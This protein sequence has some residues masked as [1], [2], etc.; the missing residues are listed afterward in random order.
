MFD[1]L[2]QYLVY[3]DFGSQGKQALKG[4]NL[5]SYRRQMLMLPIVYE[6][7]LKFDLKFKFDSIQFF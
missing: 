4:Y 5:V 7:V 1:L 3:S 2:T 6:I